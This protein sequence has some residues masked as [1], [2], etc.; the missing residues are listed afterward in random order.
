MRRQG[1]HYGSDSSGRGRG[2]GDGGGRPACG[3]SAVQLHQ[4]H[5]NIKSGY[6]RGR[7]QE[8]Q[9]LGDNER[10]P[11]HDN[12]W[13]WERDDAQ[14]KLP[15]TAMSPTAPFS[16]GREAPRSYYQNQT[17]DPR[18]PLERQ[19][20]GDP[21]S[22]PHEEDMDIGY[23]DN[24]RVMPSFECLEQRFLDDIMK[25]SKEQ[26]D[27]EDAENA[28]HRE[29]I[30]AINA[31][32][33]EQLLALRARHVSQRDEIVRKESQAR[34]QQFQQ[35]VIQTYPTNNNMGG[36]SDP[37]GFNPAPASTGEPHRSYNNSETYDSYRERSRFPGNA[38][39]QGYES[40]VPYPKG[41]AY[42]SGSRYY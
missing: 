30:N 11:Q 32:Y 22:Q 41:R 33:E 36:P 20:G 37:R 16:E 29:R 38:R 19:S 4:Q 1:G 40:K 26:T 2:R 13:R 9:A 7:Q 14:D 15:Q 18:A 28:R 8:P 23:E 17:M 10:D 35:M 27:A 5:Q 21:R 12:Q 31:Q 24:N 34:Q 39:D 3:G 42:D 6:Q 25:L